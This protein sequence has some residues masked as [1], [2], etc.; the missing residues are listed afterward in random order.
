[1]VERGVFCANLAKRGNSHTTDSCHQGN[2]MRQNHCVSDKE[3]ASHHLLVMLL[4]VVCCDLLQGASR[5]KAQQHLV[6]VYHCHSYLKYVERIRRL[7]TEY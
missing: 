2:T 1:M 7:R 6:D 4:P 3:L 5:S